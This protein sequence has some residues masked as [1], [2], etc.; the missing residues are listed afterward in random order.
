MKIAKIAGVVLAGYIT[1]IAAAA[2]FAAWYQPELP[3]I[4]VLTTTDSEGGQYRRL[5]GRFELDGVLYL[6]A[7]AWPRTWYHYAVKR[8]NVEINLDGKQLAFT[9]VPV[10]G[11]EL[12]RLVDDYPMPLWMRFLAGFP[13]R[14]FLRLEPR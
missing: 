12:Q 2:G 14:N 8:P 4:L 11:R 6:T 13:P 7:N 1:L 5:L 10:E 9:A 3:G